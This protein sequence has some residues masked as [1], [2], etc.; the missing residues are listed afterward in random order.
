M[1]SQQ[2]ALP[3]T[4]VTATTGGSSRGTTASGASGMKSMLRGMSYAEGAAMVA[5][6]AETVQLSPAVQRDAPGTPA[7]SHA[8]REAEA[9]KWMR[10]CCAGQIEAARQD[11]QDRVASRCERAAA[12]FA[13]AKVGEHIRIDF[14]SVDRTVSENLLPSEIADFLYLEPGDERLLFTHVYDYGPV[15]VEVLANDD[16]SGGKVLVLRAP[17]HLTHE[18]ENLRLADAATFTVTMNCGKGSQG[19]FLGGMQAMIADP[20][21][22]ATVAA[23]Y[24]AVD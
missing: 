19:G 6:P 20:T 11:M 14:G 21:A 15:Y 23:A 10:L 12:E 9:R 5:P 13:A 3:K 16:T 8:Q 22:T 7:A 2:H 1:T 18:L 17:C 4:A 24:K